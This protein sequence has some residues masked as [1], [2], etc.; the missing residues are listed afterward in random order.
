MA[1]SPHPSGKPTVPH[2]PPSDREGQGKRESGQKGVKYGANNLFGG[3]EHSKDHHESH[4]GHDMG[5]G[6][7]AKESEFANTAEGG[8]SGSLPTAGDQGAQD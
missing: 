8:I 5:L 2:R 7:L 4:Y 3:Y 6:G 1:V